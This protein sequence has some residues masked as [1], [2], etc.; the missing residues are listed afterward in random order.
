MSQDEE[1]IGIATSPNECV[2]KIREM[3]PSADGMTWDPDSLNCY[4]E[5]EASN[6]TEGPCKTCK[7]CIFG[8][9]YLYCRYKLIR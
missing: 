3:R 7:T 1:L 9:F 2:M 8:M 4:A 5:I 6:S